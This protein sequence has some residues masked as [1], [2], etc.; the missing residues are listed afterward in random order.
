LETFFIG[1]ATAIILF[2]KL[3]LA[4]DNS[5]LPLSNILMLGSDGPNVNKAVYRKMNKQLLLCREKSLIDIGTCNIHIVHNAYLN[6]LSKFGDASDLI[7]LIYHYFDGYPSRWE[8]FVSILNDLELP[9]KHFIKHVTSRWL[10][11][12]N[13]AE[14]LL[15]NWK[16]IEKYFFY[17][18]T[19]RKT[20][21]FKYQKLSKN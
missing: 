8:E 5:H 16:G 7:L 12:Q 11:L 15:Q 4:L 17:V 20:S 19:K 13:A 3:V 18:Y 2:E 14:R 9:T 21:Y 6:G 10:T 1:K